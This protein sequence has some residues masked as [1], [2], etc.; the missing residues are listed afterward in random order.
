ML[1]SLHPIVYEVEQDYFIGKVYIQKL[2]SN[3]E[4]NW[5]ITAEINHRRSVPVS[6]FKTPYFTAESAL[7]ALKDFIATQS[8]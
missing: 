1:I 7:Q 8:P 4:W 2:K 5:Y 3:G 6:M